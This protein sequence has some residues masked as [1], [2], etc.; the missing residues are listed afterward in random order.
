[1]TKTHLKSSTN[2]ICLKCVWHILN[3]TVPLFSVRSIGVLNYFITNKLLLL[4]V[5]EMTLADTIKWRSIYLVGRFAN[6]LKS[7]ESL[8]PYTIKYNKKRQCHE[9]DD[10]SLYNYKSQ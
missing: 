4:G 8:C 1:M 3:I 5:F 9:S 6:S 10:N 2:P 7:A